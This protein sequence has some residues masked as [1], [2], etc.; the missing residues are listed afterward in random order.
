MGF[1]TTTAACCRILQSFVR[2]INQ[3]QKSV[4]KPELQTAELVH[5]AYYVKCRCNSNR[6][7]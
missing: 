4:T 1:S 7:N 3:V 2:L 6:I 5:S